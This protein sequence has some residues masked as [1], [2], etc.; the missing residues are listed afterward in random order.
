MT[1]QGRQQFIRSEQVRLHTELEELVKKIETKPVDDLPMS[2]SAAA[3]PDRWLVSLGELME[4]PAIKKAA[5]SRQHIV[6]CPAPW[7][8]G[9]LRQLAAHDV[10][11]PG[12]P[13]QPEWALP[14][15]AERDFFIGTV[16]MLRNNAGEDKAYKVVFIVQGAEKFLALCP[17]RPASVVHDADDGAAFR[18]RPSRRWRCNFAVH[19][20]AADVELMPNAQI[21]VIPDLCHEGGVLVSTNWEP[22]PIRLLLAGEAAGV[23]EKDE[24]EKVSRRAKLVDDPEHDKLLQEL[25]W[26]AY[27]DEKVGYGGAGSM[28]TKSRGSAEDADE[29]QYVPDEDEIWAAL[30]DLE[31]ARAE[32]AEEGGFEQVD[33]GTRVRGRRVATA[34]EAAGAHALQ[35][36]ARTELGK[37]FCDRRGLA[38]TFKCTMSVHGVHSGI[39]C[40]SW[41]HRMQHFFDAEMESIEGW[42]SVFTQEMVGTYIEPIELRN[43]DGRLLKPVSQEAL[44]KVRAIPI[45]R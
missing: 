38:S 34:S 19:E 7:S 35:A 39:L 24:E 1:I 10:W 21:W 27:L 13:V 37:H 14:I 28:G 36:V 8:E 9:Y 2:M 5:A 16:L 44:C 20:N 32:V 17:L 31:K 11:E 4:S 42:D 3:L 18:V 43:L 25:P 33:F 41:C 26:L 6:E 12:R 30:R 45:G 29:E 23:E 40:R 22:M 15:I